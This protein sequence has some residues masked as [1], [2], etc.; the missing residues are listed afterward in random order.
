[1]LSYLKTKLIFSFITSKQFV[2]T[3]YNKM[4][5]NMFGFQEL[6][7]LKENTV[8]NVAIKYIMYSCLS[9]YINFMKYIRSYS[10]IDVNQLHVVKL[11]ENNN[12]AII[13]E[14]DKINFKDLDNILENVKDDNTMLN[15]IMFKFNL[16]NNENVIDLK[17]L[18]TKYK[19]ANNIYQNSIGNILMFNDIYYDDDTKLDIKLMRNKKMVAKEVLLKDVFD[20]HINYFLNEM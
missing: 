5:T 6:N 1:M 14:Q 9:K 7:I 15:V 13:I 16:V 4:M 19:D 3:Y 10:D 20:K 8:N 12:S 17:N 11:G 2:M 18:I